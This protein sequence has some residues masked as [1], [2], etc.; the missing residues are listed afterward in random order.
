[1][2]GFSPQGSGG[3]ALPGR[4]GGAGCT[5]MDLLRGA[6]ASWGEVLAQPGCPRHRQTLAPFPLPL[7]WLCL[8]NEAAACEGSLPEPSPGGGG[9][10]SPLGRTVWDVEAVKGL[11]ART[12]LG[13]GL[14]SLL[15]APALSPLW[16]TPS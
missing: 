16:L 10:K 5:P 12:A 13:F 8:Q 11:G 14:Q 15:D 2:S 9:C 3:A 1:M 6:G 7:C 4:S